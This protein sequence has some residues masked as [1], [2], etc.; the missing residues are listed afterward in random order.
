MTYK[1]IYDPNSDRAIRGIAFQLKVQASLSNF[2]NE[3]SNTRDWL[4]SIDP[5]LNNVQLN[6][7]EHTWGDI[8]ISDTANKCPIFVECVS[9]KG[10]KSIFPIHKVKKFNGANKY[11]CFGWEDEI[12]FVYSRTWNS[13][14]NKCESFSH[15]KRFTRKNIVNLRNQYQ[16]LESFCSAMLKT[17]THAT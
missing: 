11:Y 1:S 8:I 6:T 17:K 13:Y 2:F 12:R 10:E 3:V 7:L 14:V 9:L 5:F 15:Y 4:L 16:D